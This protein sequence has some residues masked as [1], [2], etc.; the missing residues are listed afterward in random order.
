MEV[1]QNNHDKNLIVN[2]KLM[3]IFKSWMQQAYRNSKVAIANDKVKKRNDKNRTN[4]GGKS[5]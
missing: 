1:D 5:R 2:G 3:H 4:I